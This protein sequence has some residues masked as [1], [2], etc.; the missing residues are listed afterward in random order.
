MFNIIGLILFLC[1][2]VFIFTL[3]RDLS[4]W[5]QEMNSPVIA[6]EATIISKRIQVSHHVHGEMHHHYTNTIYFITFE[7]SNGDRLEFK[8]PGNQYGL[9]M[10]KDKG[11][12]TYQGSRFKDFQRN[13]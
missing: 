12:L 10:E 6:V 3:V 7:L 11:A 9:L 4:Y 13:S 2:I 1:F 8:V 5:N